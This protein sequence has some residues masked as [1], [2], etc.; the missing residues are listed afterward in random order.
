MKN[1]KNIYEQSLDH[2]LELTEFSLVKYPDGWGLVD[3]QGGNIGNIEGDRF[4]NAIML[5]DRMDIY[6]EDY[7]VRPIEECLDI[8]DKSI[9]WGELAKNLIGK[10]GESENDVII[11]D[12][13]CNHSDE[14]Q[15]KNCFHKVKDESFTR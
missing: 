6:I 7:L 3:N 8:Q 5:I 2:F 4:N 15:L 10:A 14:I 11:L 13:L 12:A 9:C 1:I